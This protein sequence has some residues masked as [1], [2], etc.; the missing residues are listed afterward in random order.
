[1]KGKQARDNSSSLFSRVSW[2]IPHQHTPFLLMLRIS[3]P[4]P[5]TISGPPGLSHAE[6][7]PTGS[8]RW[9]KKDKG[10]LAS[11]VHER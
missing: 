2:K 11:R 1:M 7:I 10:R 5:K 9:E 6:E 3:D 8:S 4:Q